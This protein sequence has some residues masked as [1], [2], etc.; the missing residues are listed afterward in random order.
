[1]RS[2]SQFTNKIQKHNAKAKILLKFFFNN[3]PVIKK[4]NQL[5][6]HQQI[7]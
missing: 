5:K 2:A 4:L 6:K 3:Y 7:K 1:M